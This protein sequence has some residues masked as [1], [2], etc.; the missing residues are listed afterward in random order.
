MPEQL[1]VALVLHYWEGLAHAA[2][3]ERLGCSVTTLKRRLEAGRER[4]G[5]RLAR[6]GMTGASALTV[7]AA[8]QAQALARIHHDP[9]LCPLPGAVVGSGT[10]AS[11]LLG[12]GVAAKA[13]GVI[14]C[15][16][17]CVGVALGL[18]AHPAEPA[19][20][21]PTPPTQPEPKAQAADPLPAGATLRVGTSRLRHADVVS[22]AITA[23]GNVASFGR[24]HVVRT[25][26]GATGRP[27]GER[28]FDKDPVRRTWA[29][30]LSPDGRRLAVQQNAAV[31]VFDANSGNEL[32]SVKLAGALD[33]VAR[34]SPDGKVLALADQYNSG[35]PNK[36]QLC[37]VETNTCREVAKIKGYSSEPVFSRDGKR[38]AL[39]EGSA[40]VGVWD[41]ASGRELLRFKPD[42]WLGGT[43]DF[44]PTG[45]V[46]AVL[47]VINPPQAFHYVR[48]ST[49][50][51]PKDFTAPAVID[52]EWVRFSPDGS[53]V[54]FGGPQATVCYDAKS[55]KQLYEID[56]RA[57]I[58]P[59]FSPDGK[60][61]VGARHN[62]IRLWSIKSG[63][64]TPATAD[65]SPEDEVHGVS[66]SP[67]GKWLVTKGDTGSI[68]LWD[69]DG[70]PKEN[71][72]SNRWG[73]RYPLF[74]PDGRH[75]FGVASDAIALVRWDCPGGKESSR[76]TF[77][78]PVEQVFV[79]HFG[80]SGN[81]I[82]LAALT[83]T[84][85]SAPL[86]GQEVATLTVWDVATGKRL[87]TL[88]VNAPG[89]IGYGAFAPDL[90]WYFHGDRAHGI[91]GAPDFRL[92]L[93][94]GWS[95]ARQAAVSPDGRLLAQLLDVRVKDKAPGR[96]V[97]SYGH[98][99]ASSLV[100]MPAGT[101]AVT[102]QSDTTALVWDLRGPAR[103]VKKLTAV[104][105]ATAWVDLGGADAEKADAALWALVDG[106][107]DA[108]PFLAT[109]MKPAVAPAEERL[110]K[111]VAQLG[112]EEFADRET[113]ERELREIGD[114]AAPALRE[115]LKAVPSA[116]QA[117]RAN[118]LLHASNAPLL[119]AG[120]RLR[121]VRVVAVLERIA[122][123]DARELLAQLARGAAGARL[124]GE[125]A[126]ALK[127]LGE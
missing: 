111:L 77:A 120:D 106:G 21:V 98:S 118:A 72:K 92:D 108:G 88:R 60:V 75:L 87:E 47:G 3:A 36:L 76:Y 28:V 112:A 39:V 125:A 23:D 123:K 81:G 52:F 55:G 42:R 117:R 51:P 122:T 99:F 20:K 65:E 56:G 57:T 62:A 82:R 16:V 31:K 32:A 7:L 13:L 73:G 2:A 80:L 4:L 91:A 101:K 116:E 44:D 95:A 90:R 38:V 33:A 103:G 94:K 71:I 17:V 68:R 85:T 86:G 93:P 124:T 46:L 58:A 43:I 110:R 97:G 70:R 104:E 50:K 41:T 27:R 54:L 89:F 107:A 45:D 59:A 48:I 5:A 10:G 12:T 114:V 9:K 105:L 25:W 100:M 64:A 30:C 119:G 19:P 37:D 113:A 67:D 35:F 14:V 84:A 102:G 40:G 18:A 53:A 78:D 22:V 109:R 8:L 115:A 63:R 6:R 74:G 127:R 83:Q 96:F 69:S 11:A 26:D 24:D 66:V 1:R 121:A 79:H 34:F 61:A 15:V 126:E 29:G 49:G